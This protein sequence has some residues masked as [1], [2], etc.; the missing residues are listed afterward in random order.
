MPWDNTEQ[1]VRMTDPFEA[2]REEKLCIDGNESAFTFHEGSKI[3]WWYCLL[4]CAF[5]PAQPFCCFPL[6]FLGSIPPGWA[7][8]GWGQSPAEIAII[9]CSLHR[10]EL[11]WLVTSTWPSRTEQYYLFGVSEGQAKKNGR[12]TQQKCLQTPL[13]IGWKVCIVRIIGNETLIR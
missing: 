11:V 7:K 10:K 1:T 5:C 2:P 4:N 8:L 12:H 3:D 9:S 6:S 13:F